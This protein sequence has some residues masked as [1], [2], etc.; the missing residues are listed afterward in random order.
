MF[1]NILTSQECDH[2]IAASFSRVKRS[3]AYT[4][5]QLTAVDYRIQQNTWLSHQHDHV[6]E[7]IHGRIQHATGLNIDTAEDLQVGN[8]GEG[9]NCWPYTVQMYMFLGGVV[10]APTTE[11]C[12]GTGGSSQDRRAMVRW[13]SSLLLDVFVWTTI[14]DLMGF[15]L[16]IRLQLV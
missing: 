1:R 15:H 9:V 7:W 3:Q 2:I 6:I 5:D 12:S 4:Q 10:L 11:G 14:F 16:S 13:A 8:Y